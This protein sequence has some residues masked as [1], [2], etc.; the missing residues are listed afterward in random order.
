VDSIIAQQYNGLELIVVDDCSTDGTFDYLVQLSKE[1]LFIKV[2]FNKVNAG[3]NY[4]RNRGIEIASKKYILFLDSD[5]ALIQGS[6]NS[7]RN[8]IQANSSTKHFLFMV[9]DRLEESKNTEKSKLIQYEDWLAGNLYG[10]YTHVILTE[11]MKRY[12]FFEEF[13]MFEH[14]NWLRVKK[15]TAPQL[16]SNIIV[17]ER[18]RDRTDSLTTSSRL[19]N[20]E[21]I[22]SKFESE[23][24][25]YS[26]YHKDLKLYHPKALSFKLIYAVLLGV[27][28]H[29]KRDCRAM[30]HYAGK[31]QIKVLG[32]LA[33]LLPSSL[34]QYGIIRYSALKKR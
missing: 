12:L 7:V 5:D 28:S 31:W 27:A 19:R 29:K 16:L 2:L 22:R 1:H 26:L 18:E 34:V 11:I 15:E 8:F 24:M 10:D 25:Y 9:S 13:R 6:L 23:K 21:V 32:N 4:T 33:T 17:A 20:A 14:L 30:L 3:V